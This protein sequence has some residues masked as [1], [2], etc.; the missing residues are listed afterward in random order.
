MG[1]FNDSACRSLRAHARYLLHVAHPH[2]E[3][4]LHHGFYLLGYLI[5]YR[6]L[7]VEPCH[8]MGLAQLIFTLGFYGRYDR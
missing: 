2:I 6:M 5:R 1:N 3:G 8:L 7:S 4:C